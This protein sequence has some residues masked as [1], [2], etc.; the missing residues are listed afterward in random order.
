MDKG[1]SRANLLLEAN[2]AI[3]HFL[4]IVNPDREHKPIATLVQSHSDY[5]TE[6]EIREQFEKEIN[7][8]NTLR[9][10][11]PA[12]WLNHNDLLYFEVD[13]LNAGK[14]LRSLE[15]E[16]TEDMSS[17]RQLIESTV[18]EHAKD[19]RGIFEKITGKS[20]VERA[21]VVAGLGEIAYEGYP[22]V[23]SMVADL[24]FDVRRYEQAHD[25]YVSSFNHTPKSHVSLRQDLEWKIALANG[26]ASV[27]SKDQDRIRN[28]LVKLSDIKTN[29]FNT[30]LT[31]TSI[32]ELIYGVD[33]EEQ[34]TL[35]FS[36]EQ[37]KKTNLDIKQ[38][39]A[40]I[41]SVQN[42][43]TSNP[44]SDKARLLAAI[45]YNNSGSYDTAKY[46][47]DQVNE[48]SLIP[49]KKALQLNIDISLVD[50]NQ[51]NQYIG[52]AVDAFLENP[53]LQN[54]DLVNMALY[55]SLSHPAVIE[56]WLIPQ[57]LVV[58]RETE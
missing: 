29:H 56:T 3:N 20:L 13:I 22:I 1:T 27:V 35:Q 31:Y 17:A 26:K 47:L 5:V 53:T 55:K 54:R 41:E 38:N 24:L 12:L 33:L 30:N 25:N 21:N 42:L 57:K 11:K 37:F 46:Y 32:V 14:M 48:P 15:D 8:K 9:A 50:Q 4:N 18:S 40:P 52:P 7:K 39:N 10:L 28:A 6:N 43:L 58:L 16:L 44:C 45:A 49:Y 23:Q 51:G 19:T 2:S 36:A 34:K